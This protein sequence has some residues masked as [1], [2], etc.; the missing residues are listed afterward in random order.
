MI[1]NRR[2]LVLLAVPLALLGWADGA[3]AEGG[4]MVMNARVQPP[5]VASVKVGAMYM[6]VMNHGAASDR[7]TGISTPAAEMSHLHESREENG[8]AQMR[9]MEAL[10][11]P[12]GATVELKPGGYHV[13]LMGLK[14]PLAKGA[15][16]PFTLTF[17]KAGEVTV[18]AV[19]GEVSSMHEHGDAPAQ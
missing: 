14:Q 10:D 1:M 15:K 3:R 17:E 5:L 13:M 19:V 6:S 9:A 18:E 7:L 8:V 11:I 2:K 4:I 12:A 16:V